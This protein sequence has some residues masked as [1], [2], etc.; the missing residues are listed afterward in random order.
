M[1]DELIFV[2]DENNNPLPSLPRSEVIA[3]R[4]Y[5]RVSSVAVVDLKNKTVL[6]QKRSDT[7]DQRPGLWITEFGGKSNPGEESINTATRELEEEIGIKAEKKDLK[8]FILDKSEELKQFAYFYYLNYAEQ[9]AA[10]KP[11]P[12]EVSEV[13]WFSIEDAIKLLESDPKWYSYGQDIP[14][15]KSLLS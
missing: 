10:L 4:L 12:I 14:L 8:F 7:K 11:D 13:K 6:C 5:C 2:V 1:S 9:L 3:K 15:L